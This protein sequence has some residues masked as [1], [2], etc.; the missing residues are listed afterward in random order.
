MKFRWRR[1]TSQWLAEISV[2]LKHGQR[3]RRVESLRRCWD[4]RHGQKLGLVLV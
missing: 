2:K 1:M 4:A 3:L